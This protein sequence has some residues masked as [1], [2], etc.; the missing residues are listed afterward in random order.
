M[1]RTTKITT[2]ALAAGLMMMLA[3]PLSAQ[4]I[5]SAL[6]LTYKEQFDAADNAFSSLI[7]SEPANGKYY[8]YS[9]ENQLAS[10]Y[11]DTANVSFKEVAVKAVE[12]F[13]SNK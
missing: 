1:L 13:N 2:L 11:L 12:R 6:K 3:G 8:Y 5:N 7:K 4:D 9:G 10:Y